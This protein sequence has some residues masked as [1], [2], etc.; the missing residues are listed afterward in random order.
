M[1]KTMLLVISIIV[2][3]FVVNALRHPNTVTTNSPMFGFKPDTIKNKPQKHQGWIQDTGQLVPNPVEY[4]SAQ[5]VAQ[6]QYWFDNKAEYA[7]RDS[8][9]VMRAIQKEINRANNGQMPLRTNGI[10]Q[11]LR[12]AIINYS[13]ALQERDGL[14]RIETL[15]QKRFENPEVTVSQLNSKRSDYQL[16]IVDYGAFP[17]RLGHSFRRGIAL[18]E[19]PHFEVS[20]FNAW[21]S[22]EVAAALKKWREQYPTAQEIIL[23]IRNPKYRNYT[24]TYRPSINQFSYQYND[25]VVYS[26]KFPPDTRKLSNN[27]DAYVSGEASLYRLPKWND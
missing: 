8:D 20:E 19:S 23:K 14:Q 17:G 5:I 12:M 2:I 9:F 21:K 10:N 27:L 18:S 16:V 7:V 15:L 26:R 24:Y 11:V 1:N 25:G 6:K 13:T 4:M 22:T 3:V